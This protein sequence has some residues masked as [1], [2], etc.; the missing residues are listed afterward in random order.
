M[1]FRDRIGLDSVAL[2]KLGFSYDSR[3][4]VLQNWDW[5]HQEMQ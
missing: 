5:M 2:G 4:I 1:F 3:S